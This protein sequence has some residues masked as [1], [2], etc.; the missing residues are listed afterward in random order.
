[1]TMTGKRSGERSHQ[2]PNCQ[3]ALKTQIKKNWTFSLMKSLKTRALN[4]HL[5]LTGKIVL[6]FSAV[7][8]EQMVSFLYFDSY[9]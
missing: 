9:S 8:L 2:H 1:M 4:Q 5:L 6:K 7:L 3:L